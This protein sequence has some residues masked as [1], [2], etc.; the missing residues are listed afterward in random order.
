MKLRRISYPSRHT[1]YHRQGDRGAYALTGRRRAPSRTIGGKGTRNSSIAEKKRAKLREKAESRGRDEKACGCGMS[2]CT[3]LLIAA[4]AT[5]ARHSRPGPRCRRQSHKRLG[6]RSKPLPAC[7]RLPLHQALACSHSAITAHHVSAFPRLLEPAMIDPSL[8]FDSF[9]CRLFPTAPCP[10]LRG[11]LPCKRR[12]P[13]V[14]SSD[15]TLP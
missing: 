5:P 13:A 1:G 10:S 3:R 14:A 11:P 4:S 9:Q 7:C 2:A 12:G 6:D 8:H 15:E